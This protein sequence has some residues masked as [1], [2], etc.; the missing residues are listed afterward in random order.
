M[1]DHAYG[2]IL[3]STPG[4]IIRAVVGTDTVTIE[5]FTRSE[6]VVLSWRAFAEMAAHIEEQMAPPKEPV[7]EGDAP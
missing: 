6:Q 4:S 2:H 3:T 1:T 7:E 5:T